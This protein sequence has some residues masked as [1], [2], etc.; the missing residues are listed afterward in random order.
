MWSVPFYIGRLISQHW[1]ATCKCPCSSANIDSFRIW[2]WT[3]W[4]GLHYRRWTAHRLHYHSLVHDVVLFLLFFSPNKHMW[5]WSWACSCQWSWQWCILWRGGCVWTNVVVCMQGL[6]GR[7]EDVD[8]CIAT[9][10]GWHC[11]CPCVCSIDRHCPCDWA[12]ACS[13]GWRQFIICGM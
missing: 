11:S 3:V 6:A 12:W 5:R 13:W 2:F 7:D 9:S 4:W 1:R 8:A 10:A